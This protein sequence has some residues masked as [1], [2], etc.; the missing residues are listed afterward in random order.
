MG[1]VAR[2]VRSPFFTP[3][4]DR[5]ARN[6]ILFSCYLKKPNRK[7]EAMAPHL[8]PLEL[9]LISDLKAAG[10]GPVEIHAALESKRKKRGIRAPSLPNLRRVIKGKTYKRG[11][12]ERRGRKPKVTT[13]QAHAINNHRRA[14]IKKKDSEEEV[15]WCD[16]LKK[17]SCDVHPSTA[18]RHL[19]KIGVDVL[20]RPPRA[21]PSR[22]LENEQERVTVGK[23]WARRPDSF[24][25]EDLDLAIDNKVF[26]IPTFP[27][28][29]RQLKMAKVRG[30]LR[31]RSE[32]LEQGFTKP[33][34]KKHRGN[35]GPRVNVCA[36]IINSRVR[37]WEYLPK[38]WNGDVAAS[39]YRGP[40]AAALRKWRGAQQ[41][42]WLL[43]D[44]DPTGY[45]SKKALQAKKDVHITCLNFPRYSPDL[46]PL[47]F[48]LWHEV[49]RRMLLAGVTKRESQEA[50]K[51]RLRAT[52]KGIPAAVIRKAMLNIKV[53]ARQVVKANGG[54]IPRD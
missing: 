33:N 30:H 45:K 19:R 53:R 3:S 11:Q 38:T 6:L 34:N 18:A 49:E 42:Y 12:V 24:W 21:K 44:N 23:K 51:R 39:L 27:G 29:K 10:K 54:N 31:T 17:V 20:I 48:F 8:T 4:L 14:L 36:G 15:H 5:A 46:N 9:D 7:E 22:T 1:D 37:V 47:D 13:R 16:I 52:A 32:G 40:I 41:R 28:A 26:S 50:Y 2:Q 25:V 43:E 35:I